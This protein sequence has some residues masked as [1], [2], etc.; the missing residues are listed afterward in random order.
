MLSLGHFNLSPIPTSHDSKSTYLQKGEAIYT[1]NG[2]S[3]VAATCADY[4]QKTTY[5]LKDGLGVEGTICEVVIPGVNG[6]ALALNGK[7]VLLSSELADNLFD[8]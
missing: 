6:Y 2:N 5:E 1:E 4:Y 3:L 8:A 7:H